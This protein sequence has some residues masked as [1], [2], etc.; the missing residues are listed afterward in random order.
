[1]K[2][3]SLAL[4]IL[5]SS[6]HQHKIWKIGEWFCSFLVIVHRSW[7]IHAWS[8][9]FTNWSKRVQSLLQSNS[10]NCFCFAAK[11]SWNVKL[12]AKQNPIN[13][14]QCLWINQLNSVIIVHLEHTPKKTTKHPS[15]F[16]HQITSLPAA[17]LP[18]SCTSIFITRTAEGW[19]ESGT[20]DGPHEQ[21][22]HLWSHAV[23][24]AVL[25]STSRTHR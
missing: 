14:L 2:F 12:A 7:S 18:S 20:W 21:D 22:L 8:F 9:H 11:Q 13:M 16:Y 23:R 17:T 4:F 1:M 5:C 24:C 3:R 19:K 10:T 25:W 15:G 6:D